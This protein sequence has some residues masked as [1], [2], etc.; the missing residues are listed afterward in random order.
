MLDYLTSRKS[1]IFF[2]LKYHVKIRVLNIKYNNV[3]PHDMI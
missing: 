2:S 1:F 3:L